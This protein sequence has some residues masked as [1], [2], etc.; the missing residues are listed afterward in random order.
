MVIS[1]RGG[2]L[3]CSA[4]AFCGRCFDHESQVCG[5][6]R[7]SIGFGAEILG[8]TGLAVPLSNGARNPYAVPADQNSIKSDPYGCRQ[9]LVSVL[10]CRPVRETHLPYG[11]RTPGD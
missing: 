4:V 8:S 7:G 5:R 2:K 6:V 1:F 9:L 10:G 11:L 3:K